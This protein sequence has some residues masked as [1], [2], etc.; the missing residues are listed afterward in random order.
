MSDHVVWI[1]GNIEEEGNEREILREGI[2]LE[3]GK[4]GAWKT[5]KN[6]KYDPN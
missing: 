5:T 2:I 1:G 6:P 3:F 4:P